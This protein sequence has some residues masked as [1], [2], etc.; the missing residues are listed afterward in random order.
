MMNIHMQCDNAIE[1]AIDS[2]DDIQMRN[3]A[4]DIIAQCANAIA[5]FRDNEFDADDLMRLNSMNL[6]AMKL[7]IDHAISFMNFDQINCEFIANCLYF[8]FKNE[9]IE[10]IEYHFESYDEMI[11]AFDHDCKG[12]K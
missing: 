2:F 9:F 4:F 8:E 5:Q 12:G 6:I 7:I 1:N 3:F 11:N 10:F